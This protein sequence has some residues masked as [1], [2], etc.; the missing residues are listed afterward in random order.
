MITR[1]VAVGGLLRSL[2]ELRDETVMRIRQMFSLA[3]DV[4]LVF[5]KPLIGP[6]RRR[7]SIINSTIRVLLSSFPVHNSRSPVA[8]EL[9]FN[10]PN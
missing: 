8:R 4:S 9:R 3:Y 1:V 7:C 5:G 6:L 10:V 2:L